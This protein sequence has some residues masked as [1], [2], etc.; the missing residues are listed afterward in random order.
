VF[1]EQQ[2]AVVTCAG[3]PGGPGQMAQVV[4]AEDDRP[5]PAEIS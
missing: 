4:D 3:Y 2:Y 1:F 5:L